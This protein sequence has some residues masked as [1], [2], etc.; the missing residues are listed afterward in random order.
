LKCPFTDA[1]KI[2]APLIEMDWTRYGGHLH[3]DLAIRDEFFHCEP[4]KTAEIVQKQY[5]QDFT[6]LYDPTETD[7][8]LFVQGQSVSE[9]SVF[10]EIGDP[11][12][13]VRIT[14]ARPKRRADFSVPDEEA[15]GIAEVEEK[16]D[17]IRSWLVEEPDYN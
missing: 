11:E 15:R 9:S 4:D 8:V 16:L 12:T 6:Y 13:Y 2:K 3:T 1:A 5:V 10:A 17:K 7:H 14:T